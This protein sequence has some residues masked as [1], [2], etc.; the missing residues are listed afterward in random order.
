MSTEDI[1]DKKARIILAVIVL[2][3]ALLRI[4]TLGKDSLWVDELWSWTISRYSSLQ[5]VI[6]LGCANDVHPPGYQ[7]LLWGWMR[8]FGDS[9]VA[10][11]S[12]SVVAGLATVPM[13]FLLGRR[14]FSN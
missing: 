10:M 5:D 9:E 7:T 11:R 13:M 3:A 1:A 8:I 4:P 6:L 2:V 12:L 14:L